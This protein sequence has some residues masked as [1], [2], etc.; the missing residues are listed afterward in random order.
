DTL[1]TR[2]GKN[3]IVVTVPGSGSSSRAADVQAAA[4]AH[5]MTGALIYVTAG[6]NGT[7][8]VLSDSVKSLFPTRI[9]SP[10]TNELANWVKSGKADAGV[11]QA[12]DRIAD[13]IAGGASG[14][15]GPAPAQVVASRERW[16]ADS[17]WIW[18]IAGFF[19]AVL[20]I[21]MIFTRRTTRVGTQA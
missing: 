5:H 21:R 9:L 10:V 19:V 12:F 4:V 2:T 17:S 1:A 8:I 3:V 16:R 20:I 18:W 6:D 15:H 11:T 13:T 14:G 7:A